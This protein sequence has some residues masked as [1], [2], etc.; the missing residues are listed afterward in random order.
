MKLK[1]LPVVCIIALF[2]QCQKKDKGCWQAFDPLGYDA[3][4]VLCDQT[5][6]EA[7]AAYPQFWFYRA[8]EAKYCWKVEI[9]GNTSYTPD[10]P[11][12]IAKR[13]MEEYG[14]YRFTKTGCNSFCHLQWLQK[15]QSKI[16]GLFSPTRTISET[17]FSADS[18]SKLSV[19]RILT[20]R[21][22]ADSLITRELVSK[23]P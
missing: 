20:E 17:L 11:E 23:S 2:S 5:K 14:D 16:T 12:S 22:T 18:C 6:E 9:A 19:G 10:V 15:H 13:Y 4:L 1:L 21:E 3:G 8:G 7:E